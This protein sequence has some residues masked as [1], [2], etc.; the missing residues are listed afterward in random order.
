L[1]IEH[2]LFAKLQG[3]T[4]TQYTLKNTH[5]LALRLITFGARVQQL[6]LPD[7]TGADPN[8]IAGFVT[9][10]DYLQQPE[11]FG[12]LMGP[13]C[14]HPT[15]T[16]WQNWNWDAQ[17]VDDAVVMQLR[18]PDGV[19]DL[20]GTQTITIT[21]QLDDNN[22]WQ[23]TLQV[24]SDTPIQLRPNYNL[25]FMLTGDPARTI[26]HQQLTLGNTTT[27]VHTIQT[28]QTQATLADDRWTLNYHTSGTGLAISTFDH[29]DESTN[30]N[31][32]LGHPN[33]TVGIR[34][35]VAAEDQR[36][37]VDAAHPF[38]QTTTIKLQAN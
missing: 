13:D 19:N 15:H 16:D 24:Q 4:I 30:F 36:V 35:L 22:V 12:A 20:P 32:I 33:A 27:P 7:Q 3:E 10:Q 2:K 18:L 17:I 26:D 11:P 23:A 34:P 28:V 8:L 21:H 5:D 25:A 1:T 37:L 6:R 9:L 31:G 29:I 14:L 38:E